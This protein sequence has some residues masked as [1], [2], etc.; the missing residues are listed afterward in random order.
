MAERIARRAWLLG[1]GV[2]LFGCG[3]AEV[4]ATTRIEA[5]S[6]A[7]EA[8]PPD[9]GQPPDAGVA[10]ASTTGASGASAQAVQPVEGT[11]L[12]VP[13][14]DPAIGTV[15]VDLA[16]PLEDAEA[17]VHGVA[18][19][20]E[21]PI[22]GS[23]VGG[24]SIVV[25]RSPAVQGPDGGPADPET[26]AEVANPGLEPEVSEIAGRTVLG[27]IDSEAVPAEGIPQEARPVSRYV[28]IIDDGIVMVTFDDVGADL[29]TPY[30]EQLVG[31][32]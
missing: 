2:L 12:E 28:V 15:V 31:A 27:W 10:A 13:V 1:L 14:P 4:Q 21:G 25:D 24:V 8:P 26:V 7:Q 23:V 19:Y 6:G 22:E 5:S 9:V 11:D 20:R 18:F 3:T 29:A 17:T 30:L 32:L 16:I